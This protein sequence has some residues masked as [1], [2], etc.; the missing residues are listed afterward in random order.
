MPLIALKPNYFMPLWR[1]TYGYAT[2]QIDG[3]VATNV[4]GWLSR[5][6]RNHHK[7]EP[8]RQRS[9]ISWS[10]MSNAADR[11]KRISAAKCP[12]STAWGFQKVLVGNIRRIA[13]A[14]ARLQQWQRSAVVRWS[15]IW[16]ATSRSD[17]LDNTG[18][19]EIGRYK[20]A[21]EVKSSQ[22]YW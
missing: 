22:V 2:G 1:C 14:K 7:T 16:R 17:N 21:T 9:N 18:R 6:D 15:I 3:W 12:R 20:V 10:T 4:L 5:Y 19:L 11:S 8:C 13:R